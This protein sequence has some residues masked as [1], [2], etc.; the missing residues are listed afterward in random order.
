[1]IS[2]RKFFLST[3]LSV[4]M[5]A[6]VYA[7]IKVNENLSI[8]GFID[9]SYVYNDEDNAGSTDTANFD[10]FELDFMF[11]FTDKF[12]GQVDL[13]ASN[14]SNTS[15]DGDK[16]VDIEQAYIVY[17]F[18]S[19]FSMKAGR[20]LSY[21]GWETEEPTGLYQYSGTGYA[22]TFYGY[23]Q[24]GL[25]VK[26]SSTYFDFGISAVDEVF[27][28]GSGNAN[29]IGIEIMGAV[30]PTESITIKAFYM[31]DK[32]HGGTFED[33]EKINIWA[34]YAIGGF[35][36]AAEYNMA[37]DLGGVKD[38]EADGYLL[39]GNYAW[40]RFG[41]TLR[42]S[43][44]E[45]ENAGTTTKDNEAITIAPSM[46]VNDYLSLILEYRTDDNNGF[47]NDTDQIALEAL[48]VF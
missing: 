32:G 30:K 10:Q 45:I 43:A 46:I 44:Y 34:S 33:E 42:Y 7:E 27:V 12:S 19:G 28:G 1:M 15:N 17:D 36:F 39:M 35:T 14:D 9:M 4:F 2:L 37:D 25:S 48:V 26:Y 18:G 6:H 8:T 23:Y 5:L 40:D 13:E 21:S 3:L 31:T 16:E 38:Q 29:D 11:N 47:S 41:L 24:D 22:P 20:F